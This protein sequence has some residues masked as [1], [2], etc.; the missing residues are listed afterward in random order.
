MMSAPPSDHD[1]E[2]YSTRDFA[3]GELVCLRCGVVVEEPENME[4]YI[5][6]CE[7]R[8]M[9]N[10]DHYAGN[11]LLNSETENPDYVSPKNTGLA[12]K[13]NGGG[14][15]YQKKKV[16]SRLNFAYQ[17]GNIVGKAMVMREDPLTKEA[18]LKFSGYDK[19]MLQMVKERAVSELSRYNLS[20]VEM[21]IIARECKRI[22]SRL[23]FS[24]M[25]DYAWMAAVLNADVLKEK[26]A[27]AVERIMYD[28]IEPIRIKLL[29]RCNR[30]LA[31]E[32]VKPKPIEVKPKPIEA[33]L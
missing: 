14:R 23:F 24:E 32:L 33:K 12:Y 5:P 19:A 28:L 26:D 16:K 22:V 20:T 18:S 31:A 8:T 29:S 21:T 3:T 25:L 30:A 15:D 9:S 13:I 4:I 7:A 17:A 11:A 27:L 1:C 10:Q 2:R 6:D